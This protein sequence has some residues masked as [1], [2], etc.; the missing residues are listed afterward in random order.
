MG[1]K[2]VFLSI[3]VSAILHAV[4]ALGDIAPVVPAAHGLLCIDESKTVEMRSERVSIVLFA[5]HAEVSA[6]FEMR[7]T[8]EEAAVTIGFPS[9]AARTLEKGRPAWSGGLQDME[10]EVN[11]EEMALHKPVD[12]NERY[13]NPF[14]TWSQTFPG[15]ATT[16]IRVSY[17]VS[18][19]TGNNKA[20]GSERVKNFQ[21]ILLTGGAW[22]GAIGHAT[23]TVDLSHLA[24]PNLHAYWPF[25]FTYDET[26]MTLRWDLPEF[27]PTPHF[28]DEIGIRYTDGPGPKGYTQGADLTK[29]SEPIWEPAVRAI[30]F[31]AQDAQTE[32]PDRI[33]LLCKFEN[34]T[35]RTMNRTHWRIQQHVYRVIRQL[36]Q[37][38][39]GKESIAGFTWREGGI[40]GRAQ[41]RGC[42]DAFLQQLATDAGTQSLLA[43]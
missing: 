34:C 7:N 9:P 11:G 14:V 29:L 43:G 35:F 4:S 22:R 2:H 19:H 40:L 16:R 13:A 23:I 37:Q 17:W 21:Y 39:V 27:E 32:I 6:V 10:V 1:I 31:I 24:A 5:S 30:D 26:K 42:F 8:G 18:T 12:D 28:L 33:A 36:G 41:C 15:R 3:A 25:G 20:D 38:M